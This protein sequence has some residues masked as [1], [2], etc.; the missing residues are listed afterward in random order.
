MILL[1]FSHTSLFSFV[2]PHQVMALF[3]VALRINWNFP[4]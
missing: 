3:I 1:E 4:P 2:C